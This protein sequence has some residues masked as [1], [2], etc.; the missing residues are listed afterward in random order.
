MVATLTSKG[1]VTVP[2]A[3]RKALRLHVGDKLDF[4]VVNDA[5]IQVVPKRSAVRDLKG[6]IPPPRTGVSLADMEAAIVA[7]ASRS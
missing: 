5:L 6:M 1:Q 7:G 2:N 3:I 4:V